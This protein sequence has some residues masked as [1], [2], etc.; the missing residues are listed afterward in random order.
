MVLLAALSTRPEIRP[1]LASRPWRVIWKFSSRMWGLNALERVAIRL[2]YAVI[3]WVLGT[4][5]MGVYYA[6][7]GV[8]EGI[9]GFL[10]NPV[11]TVLYVFY[12]KLPRRDA[13]IDIVR[14]YSVGAFFLTAV[15]A[16][17]FFALPYPGAMGLL[18]GPDYGSGNQLIPGL[19][20]YGAAIIWFEN[21]K[22]LAMAESLHGLATIG[23]LTQIAIVTVPLTSLLGLLGAGFSTGLCGLALAVV[24]TFM[25]TRARRQ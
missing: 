10:T 1:T 23:R 7:R 4:E 3:G 8:I 14:R 21:V 11:Q 17:A 18:L 13:V 19:V 20:F 16:A 5:T 6:C 25:I 9:L 15:L 12:C 22:V 2:D 24:S